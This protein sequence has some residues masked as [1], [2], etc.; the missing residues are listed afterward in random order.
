[1]IATAPIL[2]YDG[3]RLSQRW[4]KLLRL[5]P[6]YDPFAVDRELYRFD[7]VTGQ[8]VIDFFE[9]V[10]KHVKGEKG[11]QPFLLERWQK[12]F[13]ANLYGWKN[14]DTTLRR[15]RE[16]FLKVG[17]KNGKTP[18]AAGVSLFSLVVDDEPGSEIYCAAADS[19]QAAL[20]FEHAAGMVFQDKDL[21]ERLDVFG[22]T[23]GGQRKSIVYPE[24]YSSIRVLS[25]EAKTKHGLNANLV[26]I[27]ELHAQPNRELVDVLT[28][29][30]GA[31]R[32]PIILHITTSDYA[33]E[34][35][36]NEKDAYAHKVRDGEIDDPAFLPA[37]YEADKKDDHRAIAT[38]RRANPNLDVS[39]KREYIEREFKRAEET[40]SYLNTVLR[41]HLNIR[42]Q[43][44]IRW[45][46]L[47]A[48][49]RG[50]ADAPDP[51]AWRARMLEELR[52]ARCAGGLDIGSVRDL[53]ALVLFF[54][55][56]SSDD[57]SYI[58]LPWFWLPEPQARL[59][60]TKE[61]PY[62]TWIRQGFIETTDSETLD[63]DALRRDINALGD[64]FGIF[65]LAIDRMFQ[66]DQLMMQLAGDGFEMVPFGQG[67]YS[68]AAPSRRFEE[69]VIGGKIR[70]G[71]NPVL[72]WM[73]MNAAAET[74][75]AGN[76]KP[77]KKLATERIDGIVAEIMA[78]GRFMVSDPDG[79]RSIYEEE[80][81]MVL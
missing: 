8:L 61:A 6:G 20:V 79:D 67:F 1:M 19:D 57:E 71:M 62:L 43:L 40:P 65:E 70:H 15:Y 33:R 44:D 74:D 73:A 48:W 47:E 69:L 56:E 12:S 31:R 35:I 21:T 60:D 55:D 23:G 34:S 58:A 5:L 53:T 4:V 30:V 29:A 36:C 81:L 77:S 18:I 25:A 13:N 37:I 52:G 54:E 14:I 49:D 59:R 80:D 17:R 64:D 42:T 10:L 63:Y 2:A 22:A 7:P 3:K 45:L 27:D 51:V 9:Q 16:A 28:T 68:M 66:G 76:V 50:G 46:D 11:G 32:Q 72:R 75:A 41:L 26:I 38:W 39:V 78:L 24:R